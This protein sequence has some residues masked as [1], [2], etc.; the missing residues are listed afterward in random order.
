MHLHAR[1]HVRA[2]ICLVLLWAL[3]GWLLA[4]EEKPGDADRRIDQLIQ[5]LGDRDYFVR[6]RA[7]SELAKLGFEAFD[8][9][10]AAENHEDLEIATRAKY[11]LRLMRVN[12]T[13]EDDPPEIKRYLEDYESLNPEQR[14][15]RMRT[16]GAL[17]GGA[18]TA[19]LCRLVRFEKSP[20]LS[21]FAAVEVLSRQPPDQPPTDETAA[22]LR[23][24][25]GQGRRAATA[26]LAAYL[27]FRDDAAKALDEWGKLVD[28][29]VAVL[30]R[31]PDQ[32][33]PQVVAALVRLQIN[34]L[35]KLGRKEEAVA[36]MWRLIDLEKG[37]P[38]GLGELLDWLVEQKAWDA[39]E[40]VAE[41]FPDRFSHEPVLLYTVAQAQAEQGKKDQAEE[42]AQKALKLNA[43]P[44]AEEVLLHLMAAFSLQRRGL[45]KWAEGEF[46]H[47]M[48]I[49]PMGHRFTSLAHLRL[50]EMLHDEGE[51]L[52]AAEAIQPL[53]DWID[54]MDSPPEDVEGREPG[55]VRSRMNYFYARHWAARGDRAKEKQYLEA[56]L[57]AD[58]TDADVLI[59]CY[60][61]PD[62]TAEWKQHVKDLI[63]KAVDVFREQI[64]EDP[65]EATPYNQYAWLVGNTEGDLDE[66]L[67]F[68]LKS[69]E[70]APD[71]GGFY[72]TLARVYFAR[73]DL[74]NAVKHQTKAVEMEPHSG[75][76][77][78]QLAE[79]QE[80]LKKQTPVKP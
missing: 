18:G 61:L 60:R 55:A 57:K 25:M 78:K 9:L 66:A 76:I 38:K 65:E 46:R 62:A 68:S 23:K 72:D 74:A 34:W 12:W 24:N 36:A 67:R 73:G 21:K 42:T 44:Q 59:A 29:E 37:D 15:E 30:Q 6:Q 58:P 64:N 13:A 77:R 26:W 48:A 54:K 69:I 51:E 19:A 5:E 17:P 52:R 39:I 45:A 20:L 33:H 16:L 11:L 32:S 71:A 70:L 2:A 3:S 79:F 31:T 10:S 49:S 43:G 53:I 56:G 7:Q 40:K 22:A 80:A 14:K 75:L 4:A 41:R 47:V 50:S 8:A 28:E 27:R 63:K 35:A 1:L